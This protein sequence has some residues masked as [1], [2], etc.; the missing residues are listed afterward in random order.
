VVYGWVFTAHQVGGSIAATGAAIL[1]VH[2]GNYALAFY[3][4]GILCLASSYVVLQI[5]KSE[6]PEK[7]PISV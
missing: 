7:T 5:G 3:I 2:F 6:K 4:A 1:R